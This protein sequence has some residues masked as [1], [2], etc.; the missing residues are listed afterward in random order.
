MLLDHRLLINSLHFFVLD[1]SL[2][3][4]HEVLLLHCCT[5][6][7]IVN[8]ET[9]RIID[10]LHLKSIVS[11]IHKTALETVGTLLF[12]EIENHIPMY[13]GLHLATPR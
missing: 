6:K 13:C 12:R 3:I 1:G 11:H 7:T 4:I 5:Y 9:G 2:Y 8:I 10:R